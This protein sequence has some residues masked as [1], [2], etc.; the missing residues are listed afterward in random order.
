MAQLTMDTANILFNSGKYEDAASYYRR[1]E[2][3]DPKNDQ[4]PFAFY[5]Q[6]LSLYRAEYYN[7]AADA[8]ERMA[9]QYP[10]DSAGGGIVVS[11]VADA[12]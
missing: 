8:W 6:A 2:Q 1:L 9:S 7:D 12:I 3:V 10:R 4:R 11:R 5:Q